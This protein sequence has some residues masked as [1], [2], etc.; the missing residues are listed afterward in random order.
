MHRSIVFF[1]VLGSV[2]LAA[3]SSKNDANEKNFG[4]AINQYF[5]VRDTM[6][7]GLCLN[8]MEWPVDVVPGRREWDE[9]TGRARQMTTLE[10]VGLVKGEEIETDDGKKTKIKRYTLTEA[11]K[12]FI[13]EK[14]VDHIGFSD[15]K[16]VKK[17]D[18]CWGKRVVD[19]VVKW[20]GPL[21]LGDYQE[22]KVTYTYKVINLV[23]WAKKPEVQETFPVIKHILDGAGTKEDRHSVHLT[24]Q[25]WEASGLK[26]LKQRF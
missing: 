11:A 24:S 9:K 1:A 2:M 8:I 5:E 21:K 17:P 13:Q 26:H 18:I 22:A 14:D 16:T 20:E 3:C 4:A 7:G 19:K 15:S 23:E 25:G 6:E 12:P 10:A